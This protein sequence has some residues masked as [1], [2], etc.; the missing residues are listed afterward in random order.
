MNDTIRDVTPKDANKVYGEEENDTFEKDATS[1]VVTFD[2]LA[3][4]LSSSTES[5]SGKPICE[6]NTKATIMEV[7]LKRTFEPKT[8]KDGQSEYYPLIFNIHTRTEDGQDS[9]D[10]YGGLRETEDGLWSGEKSAFGKL[11]KLAKEEADIK[12]YADF[13]NFVKAGVDVKIRTET[14]SFGDNEYKKNIIK[15]FI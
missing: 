7:E 11:L 3:D 13:F 5:G 1:E 2:E 8:T 10:N 14:T 6:N 15:Q 12:T 4:K 9:F